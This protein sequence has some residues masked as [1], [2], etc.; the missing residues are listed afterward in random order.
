MYYFNSRVKI[1][2]RESIGISTIIKRIISGYTPSGF[3][4]FPPDI[5]KS[6]LEN[7]THLTCQFAEGAATEENVIFIILLS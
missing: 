1:L 3:M 7:T 4:Q 2:D 5:V 6:F